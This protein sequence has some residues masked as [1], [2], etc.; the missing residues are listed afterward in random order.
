MSE[1][2]ADWCINVLENNLYM[3]DIKKRQSDKGLWRIETANQDNIFKLIANVYDKPFG[4][5]RK[6]KLLR[7]TFNDYNRT[8]LPI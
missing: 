8:S 4:M 3:K 1:D 5:E 7:E 6:Y 2:F